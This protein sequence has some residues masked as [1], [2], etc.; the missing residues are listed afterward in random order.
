MDTDGNR[1]TNGASY[2]PEDPAE[3]TQFDALADQLGGPDALRPQHAILIADLVRGERLKDKLQ[4]DIEAR[5]T[6]GI[7]R[8]GRQTYWKEN[9][10]IGTLMKLMD[11]QRRTLQA[12]G[13]ITKIKDQPE[14][15][16]DGDDFEA[17]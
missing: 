12:L 1:T 14:T 3:A 9:K 5:G 13:L 11:Q 7:E 10:S 2:F 16:D 6:G 8:N 15:E 4:Q 17:F